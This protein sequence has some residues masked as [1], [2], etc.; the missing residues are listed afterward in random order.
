ML[1]KHLALFILEQDGE[2]EVRQLPDEEGWPDDACHLESEA[3][4]HLLK[5][6]NG[7]GA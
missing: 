5:L 1:L 6:L 3:W 4:T 2:C 7:P